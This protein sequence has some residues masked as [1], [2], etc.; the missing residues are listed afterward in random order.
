[1]DDAP[2]L[3]V[4]AGPTGMTAALDLAHYGIRS[5]L[6]DE[7]HVLSEGSR[8]IAYSSATLATWEKLG[9]VEPMLAKG[10]AWSVRHTSFRDRQLFTQD[11]PPP[12]PG[13]MPRFFQLAAVLCRALPA[14]LHRGFP[15]HR[16]AL[17]SQ[18]YRLPR[19][20]CY[21]FLAGDD[22]GG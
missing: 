14:G 2:I 20:Y 22:A 6:L 7:D 15:S 4:G 11:F 9:A 1:M 16:R 13:F 19:G 5:T 12:G 8:A 21:G 10:V 3:I 17:G 18:S